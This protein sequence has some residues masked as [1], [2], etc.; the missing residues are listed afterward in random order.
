MRRT[1]TP[2]IQQLMSN[3]HRLVVRFIS[4]VIGT[5]TAGI[6]DG[7]PDI[8]IAGGIRVDLITE[9]TVTNVVV[10]APIGAS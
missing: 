6:G 10:I 4:K 1:A 8:G 3:R 7:T 5:M 2:I 9:V